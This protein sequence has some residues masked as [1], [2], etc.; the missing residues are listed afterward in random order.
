MN[1][2]EQLETGGDPRALADYAALRDELAKLSHPARPDVNWRRAE[3]LSLSLFR[4]NGVELQTAVWYTLARSHL[5]GLYGLNEGLAIL[6]ALLSHRWDA[7]WPPSEQA[8]AKI[9]AAFFP[10]LQ[11]LLRTLT[12]QQSDLPQICQAERHLNALYHLLQRRTLNIASQAGELAA[13]LH[14]AARRL[15][16]EKAEASSHL[17]VEQALPSS[18]VV[19]LA[20]SLVYVVRDKSAA[21]DERSWKSFAAGMLTMLTLGVAGVWGWQQLNPPDNGPLPVKADQASLKQ[22]AQLSPLWR[23]QYGFILSAKAAPDLSERLKAQWQQHIAG[24]ALPSEALTGWHQGMEG[25]REMTRQLNALDL[26]KR[27]YL[28]GSELKTMVFAITQ[29]FARAVPVEEQ[30]YQLSQAEAGKPLPETLRVET[31]RHFDQLLN[32]YMLIRMVSPASVD[33]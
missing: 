30:L 2:P 7:M 3:Q 24:N 8:R 28:T 15:E 32:R 31:D 9:F 13:F 33:K 25:L 18:P 14:Q 16:N 10:R 4:Q 12:L 23:Q 6:E 20:R 29:N 11:A 5:A 21:P 26:R 17:N 1:N 27:K 22:L 19:P